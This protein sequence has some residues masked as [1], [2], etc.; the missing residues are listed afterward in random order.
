MARFELIGTATIPGRGTELKLLQ[1]NDEF[2]IKIAGSTG[3]LMNSRL[4]GSEDA[5]AT[6]ACERIAG[7]PEPHVL[8]GGLGMGFT[9]A[10]AL[11][12]LGGDAQVTVAELVP[13]VVEWNRG[14]LGAAAGNPLRD[15]RAK[16]HLGDVG[17]LLQES[18]GRYD[19][20]LLDVD[21][22]PEG[23]TRKE[24]DWIYSSAGIAAAQSALRPEGILA[25]W[26]AGQDHD[27][28]ERLRKMGFAV[29]AVTVRAHRP[30][31][32]ARHVIWLAW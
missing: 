9:L 25:Y 18:D 24:N 1:R 3:E 20:I 2:S 15:P 27:F 31:K 16:V 19:A 12:S 29:E 5:L 30:G 6:L 7:N 26:S 21:N 17:L 32:G 4:H 22:G 13:E 8:I 11:E 23:L 10:A 28:T 14:A